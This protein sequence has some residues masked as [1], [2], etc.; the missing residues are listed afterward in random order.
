MNNIFCTVLS[1]IRD[2]LLTFH[3]HSVKWL[4]YSSSS[5]FDRRKKSKALSSE[6]LAQD[7]SDPIVELRFQ[8]RQSGTRASGLPTAS[9]EWGNEYVTTHWEAGDISQGIRASWQMVSKDCNTVLTNVCIT[10][11]NLKVCLHTVSSSSCHPMGWKR[12]SSSR[13]ML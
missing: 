7:H 8:R 11:Y 3:S 1:A 6:W 10:L 9:L 4:Y 2:Y 5:T 12:D 13:W